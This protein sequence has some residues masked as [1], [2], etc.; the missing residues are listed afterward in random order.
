MLADRKAQRLRKIDLSFNDHSSV[1]SDLEVT[2][3]EVSGLEEVELVETDLTTEQ[4]TGIY[5]MVADRRCSRLREINLSGIDLS[6]VS[7]ELRDR[8][9]LNQSVKIFL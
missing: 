6:S 3:M 4:L 7:Q 8:A 5:T 2:A 1:R 9:E